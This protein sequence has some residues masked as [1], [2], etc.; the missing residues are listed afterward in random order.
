MNNS[1]LVSIL[2]NNYNYDKYLSDAIESAINQTYTPV[3]VIVV[4]DGSTDNSKTVLDGYSG[5]INSILKPN[6]GQASAINE[7]FKI[8]E[9]KSFVFWILTIGFLRKKLRKWLIFSKAIRKLAGS[10]ML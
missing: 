7:G 10:S 6:A 9:G 1:P 4:D 2:V 8:A 3:E 5:K